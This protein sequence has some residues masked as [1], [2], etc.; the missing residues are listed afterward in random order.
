MQTRFGT[1]PSNRSFVPV[2]CILAFYTLPVV[3]LIAWVWHNTRPQYH[4]MDWILVRLLTYPG[5][6]WEYLFS[7]RNFVPMPFAAL[8]ALALNT[9][10]IC[11]PACLV[12]RFATRRH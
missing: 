8:V 4:N 9:T 7:N 11:L 10:A 5:C 1:L 12:S 6:G 3:I 2:R